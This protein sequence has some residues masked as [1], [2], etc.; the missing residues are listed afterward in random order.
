MNTPLTRWAALVLLLAGSASAQQRPRV[1]IINRPV[2]LPAPGARPGLGVNPREQ[3]TTPAWFDWKFAAPPGLA[4]GMP[5]GKGGFP[6]SYQLVVPPGLPGGRRPGLV[7]HLS[8]SSAPADHAHWEAVCRKYGLIYASPYGVGDEAHAAERLRIALA[9]LDDVRQKYGPDT[10]RIYITGSSHGALTACL[11]AYSYPE[12]VGG[13]LAVGAATSLRS[14]PWMRDRVKERLS[15][16]LMT[17]Q[18]DA[19]RHELER[20]RF[21][22]LRDTGVNAKL[23]LVPGMA[24]GLPPPLVLDQAMAWL[25]LNRVAR[26]QLGTVAPALRMAEKATPRA[27]E[28][29]RAVYDE[30][31]MR[32]E[33]RLVNEG[34]MLLEG[35]TSRWPTTAAA[36]DAK[37]LLDAHNAKKK[38]TWGDIYNNRQVAHFSREAQA[39]DEYLQVLTGVRGLTVPPTLIEAAISMYEQVTKFGPETRQG[40][41]AKA[42]LEV[43]RKPKLGRAE[44]P[45]IR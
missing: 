38:G 34:L 7:L 21:T 36:R 33:K 39:L 25:E 6:D 19:A 41:K 26:M 42:R 1:I 11:I 9:V 30:A 22:S 37:K 29:A 27:D 13:L 14:E 40:L 35:V 43:L 17:G 45:A 4:D 12:F 15:V 2:Y 31:K 16:V 28:W 3:V 23:V 24:K 44:R 32:M 5:G 10:D 8:A 18:L 20:V